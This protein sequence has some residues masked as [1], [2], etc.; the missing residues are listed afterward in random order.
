M[1]KPSLRSELA[2]EG[3]LS[4]NTACATRWFSNCF[5]IGLA[6]LIPTI[7]PEGILLSFLMISIHS[8]LVMSCL[9]GKNGTSMGYC[10]SLIMPWMLR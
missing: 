6:H 7:E 9:M 1:R 3:Q 10:L 2:A 5:S 4:V 8:L